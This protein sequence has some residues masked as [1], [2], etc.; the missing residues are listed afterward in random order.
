MRS[1]KKGEAMEAPKHDED[2]EELE[3]SEW[4]CDDITG[5]ELDPMVVMRKRQEEIGYIRK[6]GVYEKV[7]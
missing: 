2:A 3:G 6:H 4:A 7:K 1:T 5:A